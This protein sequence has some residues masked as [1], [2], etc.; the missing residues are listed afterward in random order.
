MFKFSDDEKIHVSKLLPAA[1]LIMAPVGCVGL[2]TIITK[3][4]RN[5]LIT[6]LFLSLLIS[7]VYVVALYVVITKMQ[8]KLVLNETGDKYKHGSR[9]IALIYVIRYSIRLLIIM[10]VLANACKVLMLS[11]YNSLVIILPAV[12]LGIVMGVRG[13]YKILDFYQVIFIAVIILLI[14]TGICGIENF[15]ADKL[16]SLVSWE[17]PDGIAVSVC[18][19]M[20]RGYMFFLSFSMLEFVV[21][22]YAM[23]RGRKRSMLL[24]SSGIAMLIGVIAS[25]FVIGLLGL[26][27]LENGS[28]NILHVVGALKLPFSNISHLGLPICTLFVIS[29]VCI[30]GIHFVFTGEAVTYAWENVRKIPFMLV[31][32]TGLLIIYPFFE[33]FLERAEIYTIIAGY[34][35]MIDIP[36]SILAPAFAVRRKLKLKETAAMIIGT[37][38]VLLLAG[39]GSKPLEDVDYLTVIILDQNQGE[40]NYTFV[41]DT[42][43]GSETAEEVETY[44]ASSLQDAIDTYDMEHV[45]SLDSSHTEYIVSPDRAV[46]EK[47][48][49]EL[50]EQFAV[51]YL[52]VIIDAELA[53]NIGQLEENSIRK[54]IENHYEGQCMATLEEEQ[55]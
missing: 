39:C 35:G 55:N 24:Y 28:K 29:G 47:V 22:I 11:G 2:L 1:V 54:Y 51:S 33:N 23:I 5:H 3:T 19:I 16:A 21:F 26:T 15:S 43:S 42:I 38:L 44:R 27:S 30:L 46:Y 50:N 4:G 13:L 37:I 36:L 17:L 14:F 18:S 52:E 20:K 40:I 6:S 7:L 32:G 8:K 45:K 25:V 9:I 31:Y 53:A 41:V 34:M 12:L 48:S 10:Y 49:S